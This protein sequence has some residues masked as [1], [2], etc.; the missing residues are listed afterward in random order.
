MQ[1]W[2]NAY[3][4]TGQGQQIAA[5]DHLYQYGSGNSAWYIL[6][7]PIVKQLEPYKI[8]DGP[9]YPTKDGEEED[10]D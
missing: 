4:Y 6:D 8:K 5:Q 7:G 3:L 9:E 10:N 1:S 2:A